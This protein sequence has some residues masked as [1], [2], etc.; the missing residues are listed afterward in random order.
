LTAVYFAASMVR[1]FFLLAPAFGLVAA[2]GITGVLKPFVVLLREPPKITK[3]KLGLEH[4]G[5]EFSGTAIFLMFLILMTNLA[6]S[7]QSGGVPS[8]YRQVYVPVSLTA[9]SLPVI[10]SQP[11]M[12][13]YDALA[14][15]KN[16]LE[17]TTIVV[18]WWDY[19]YW[20]TMVGN[21][22]T[23]NDNLTIN[24]TQIENV[25]F[26]FMAN[27][28]QSLEM[29]AT[30]H[31][32]YILTFVTVGETTGT[33]ST[34]S[35]PVGTFVGYGDE[36]KWTWMAR[37]S[38]EAQQRLLANGYDCSWKDETAFGTYNTTSGN[39]VWNDFGTNSTI[40]K[41]MTWGLDQ[42]CAVG[43]S[44]VT[45]S[46]TTVEPTYFKEAYFSGESLSH[47]TLLRT[48]TSSL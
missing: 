47:P 38:G 36:G 45:P 33:T 32:D 40:Y 34:G 12:E 1:L 9:A 31:A 30:Y 6:F 46:Q 22:T 4:V 3:K 10:P 16:N 21:V 17:S 2:V 25:G 27:E 42:W 29:L 11:I 7:P 37:I 5:K 18:S 15:I 26:M 20:L 24:S 44:G 23:L 39:W 43:G 14:W 28:T 41:L 8:V 35:I 19:G 13:W 48:D